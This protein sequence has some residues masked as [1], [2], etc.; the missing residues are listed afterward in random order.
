MSKICP[1][2]GKP[3]IESGLI[4]C[5]V[6]QVPF[7]EESERGLNLSKEELELISKTLVNSWRFWFKF[8]TAFIIAL[9]LVGVPAVTMIGVH[10]AMKWLNV[11][12]EDFNKQASNHLATAYQDVTNR[13]A[14]AL[15]NY[16]QKANNQLAVAYQDTERASCL[17]YMAR[18][19]RQCS[20][21]CRPVASTLTALAP[22]WDGT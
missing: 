4:R 14:I 16:E 13:T 2:C 21:P 19:R 6:C 9:L 18:S 5:H 15:W 22:P 1:K 8:S 7:I 11:S 17:H 12:L 3:P 10:F 20:A